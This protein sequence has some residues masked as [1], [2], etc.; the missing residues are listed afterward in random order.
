V[1]DKQVFP[2]HIVF[3]SNVD[4]LT[5]TSPDI[6]LGLPVTRE[7]TGAAYGVIAGFQ[8]TPDELTA[9]RKAAGG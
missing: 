6:G 3:P 4:K 7:K 9:N 2:V 8:L 1:R 5:V